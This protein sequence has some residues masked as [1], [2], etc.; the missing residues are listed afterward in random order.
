MPR[1]SRR[2]PIE[3]PPNKV[4]GIVYMLIGFMALAVAAFVLVYRGAS[5]EPTSNI[6]N[7]FGVVIA[8][9]GVFRI[10]TGF[11]TVRRANKLTDNVALNGQSAQQKPPV[12]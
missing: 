3:R 7:G 6:W 8:L 1:P 11:M 2:N 4:A 10:V 9:Y 12:V 5:V